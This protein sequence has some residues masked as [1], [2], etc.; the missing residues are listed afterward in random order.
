M[1]K[2]NLILIMLFALL[3][4]RCGREVK[5][6]DGMSN[7]RKNLV[8]K[9]Q[10]QQ[11]IIF[12]N[13]TTS[14]KIK[15]W[16]NKVAQVLNQNLTKKQR[17][18]TKSILLEI[19]L[20]QSKTYDGIK[21]MELAIEMAKITPQD[22]FIKMFVL[23]ED[24]IR[25]EK[26]YNNINNQLIINDLVFDLS[27]IKSKKKKLFE[28]KANITEPNNNGNTQGSIQPDCNCSW[29]CGFYGTHHDNC[30]G[31]SSGC[32][33]LGWGGCGGHTGP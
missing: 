3:A 5:L 11:K 10:T 2:L 4:T 14:T 15:F 32:G 6:D 33:F 8:S 16:E 13:L 20:S 31:T 7:F 26:S 19:P 17:I 22:E 27:Q 18:L 12:N 9:N 21:I 24:Y 28:Q 23:Y 25:N 30:T 29:T 1:K